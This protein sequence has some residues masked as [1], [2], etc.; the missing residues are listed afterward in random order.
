ML[1]ISKNYVSEIHEYPCRVALG[2][3]SEMTSSFLCTEFTMHIHELF[4]KVYLQFSLNFLTVVRFKCVS[5]SCKDFA[6]EIVS[7]SKSGLQ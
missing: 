4:A 1:E 6:F 5:S 7:F 3:S 2:S